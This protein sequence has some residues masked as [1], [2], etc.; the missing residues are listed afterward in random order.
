LRR[1]IILTPGIDPGIAVLPLDDVV[2]DQFHV[3]LGHRIFEPATDQALHRE[4]GIV[5][6]GHRLALGRLTDQTLTIL[7]E[8]HDR[9]R[10][11]RA[12][13]ILDNLGFAPIHHRHAG[14]GG[15]EV[16]TDNFRHYFPIHSVLGHRAMCFPNQAKQLGGSVRPVCYA[17]DIGAVSLGTREWTH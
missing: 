10:C 14:V 3:L 12:F 5:G 16:D 8:C 15:A 2:G 7:G 1:R 13:G 4:N 11:A 17:G 9:R 6:V